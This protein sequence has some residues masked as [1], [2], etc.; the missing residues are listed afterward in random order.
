MTLSKTA[1]PIDGRAFVVR[2][3]RNRAQFDG[4]PDWLKST[5]LRVKTT[6]L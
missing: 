2:L 5:S 6:V 1:N 4:L 3:R